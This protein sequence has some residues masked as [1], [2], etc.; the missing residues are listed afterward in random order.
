MAAEVVDYST[1]AATGQG[2][3]IEMGAVGPSESDDPK[4]KTSL[5]A[6]DGVNELHLT[7]TEAIKK[8][9]WLV[10]LFVLIVILLPAGCGDKWFLQPRQRFF[11]SWDATISYP[12]PNQDSFNMMLF[13][14]TYI[15]ILLYFVLFE[16]F[17][18]RHAKQ[19]NGFRFYTF[20]Y[21]AIDLAVAMAITV[22]LT[23]W[24]KYFVGRLRPDF[25][26]RCDLPE[27]PQDYYIRFAG[28]DTSKCTN[29]DSAELKEGRV[30][31]PSGHTSMAFCQGF[32]MMFYTM[33]SL[34]VRPE[35]PRTL[36]ARRERGHVAEQG[37]D[38]ARGVALFIGPAGALFLAASRLIDYKHHPSDV[39]AGA[40]LGIICAA[41]TFYRGV[42][43]YTRRLDTIYAK[44]MKAGQATLPT[45]NC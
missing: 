44:R 36:A 3:G 10:L 26:S 34:Y 45:A 17:L 13:V 43:L 29:Q 40:M 14:V 15:A 12:G 1:E 35:D 19:N 31:Y 2:K 24:L 39:N 25:L 27:T 32:Y 41:V 30:S 37:L 22:A 8:Q 20:L 4:G 16:Q 11:A 7:Y 5:L 42:H 23:V 28:T 9:S 18:C 6:V 21:Y 38:I 33:W